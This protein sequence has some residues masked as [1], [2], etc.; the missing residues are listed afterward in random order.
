M[1]RWPTLLALTFVSSA[2]AQTTIRGR[3]LVLVDTSG[4]MAWHFNDCSSANGDGASGVAAFCDNGINGFTCNAK[5]TCTPATGAALFQANATNPSR[6]LAAK[7]A[8]NDVIN[9]SSG[10]V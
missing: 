2:V 6:L 8:L 9:S 7:A 1:L 10:S 5:T 3:V 4:S